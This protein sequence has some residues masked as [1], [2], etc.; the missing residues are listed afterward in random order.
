[1]TDRPADRPTHWWPRSFGGR[2]CI[3]ICICT[4]TTRSH[5]HF[6]PT[7]QPAHSSSF[8]RIPRISLSLALI[9]IPRLLTSLSKTPP[10]TPS[11]LPLLHSRPRRRDHRSIPSSP[12]T[13]H[14]LL[15]R[16]ASTLLLAR[17]LRHMLGKHLQ[18]DP[19]LGDR[20]EDMP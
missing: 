1:M 6:S 19:R 5:I 10:Q 8:P 13:R 12:L 15:R 11:P 14:H 17:L 3:R 20:L 9:S 4:H 16:R 2:I 7:W 18:I